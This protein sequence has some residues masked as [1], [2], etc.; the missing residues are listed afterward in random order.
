MLMPLPPPSPALSRR[1][2]VAAN[3]YLAAI[4]L[5]FLPS[6]PTLTA[7]PSS[8]FS[9][10]RSLS[11]VVANRWTYLSAV[12]V[13]HRWP[14]PPLLSRFF[15]AGKPSSTTTS[16]SSAFSSLCGSR[17]YRTCS[18][19]QPALFSSPAA[20]ATRYCSRPSSLLPS[21]SIVVG[22]LP[23]K[24]QQRCYYLVAPH[25]LGAPHDAAASSLATVALV[26]AAASNRTPCRC[27]SLLPPL[28]LL[29]TT[30]SPTCRYL[31]LIRLLQQP[32]PLPTDAS[33]CYHCGP[34]HL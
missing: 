20:V 1:S 8:S 15:T 13:T 29:T 7:Q 11:V 14:L 34:N 24:H 17:L 2:I 9:H 5:T 22:P 33:S 21:S 31:L 28:Y 30:T 16:I 18:C 32:L 23:L 26:A 19:R 4:F 27:T 10:Y 3:H 12:T 6:L 25:L